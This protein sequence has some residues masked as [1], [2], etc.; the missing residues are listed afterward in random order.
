[1]TGISN[2]LAGLLTVCIH[3][4][5]PGLQLWPASAFALACGCTL[6]PCGAAADVLSISH[7]TL[8]HALLL[9]CHILTIPQSLLNYPA[10]SLKSHFAPFI[11][12][13]CIEIHNCAMSY[14]P[15]DETNEEVRLLSI[16]P[17][18]PG[19]DKLE[20]S[21]TIVSL[22]DLKPEH[23]SF[24]RRVTTAGRE[25]RLAT[26]WNSTR[27]NPALTC[28][29]PPPIPPADSYRFKWGD[30]ATLSYT[31]GDPEI[32]EAIL[33]DG[34]HASVTTNLA[35]A[36]RTFRKLNY[37]SGRFNLWVDSVCINQ[38]DLDERSSQVA[39]MRDIYA[40]SWTTMTFLGAAA[41]NSDKALGL[42]KTLA[43][44]EVNKTT[45]QLRDILQDH[46]WHLGGQ[47]E[48]LALQVFLQRR[49]WS[50]LW[51]VQ[52]SALAPP[53]MLMFAGEDSITWQEVQ[54]GL[55]SIHTCLWYVKD[56]CL[57]HD[58]RMFQ[59]AQGIS[60]QVS[61]RWDTQN[62]HH[63]DKGP[64][65]LARKERRGEPLTYKDLLEVAC[66]TACAD[67]L[68]KVYGLLAF[69][70]PTIAD[71]VV[72]DYRLQPS[73]LFFQLGQL[74]IIHDD[75]LELLRDGNPWNQTK[76]PSWAPDW[77]WEYH[78]RDKLFPTLPYQA[79]GGLPAQYSFSADGRLLTVRGV[80]VDTVEGM[81]LQSTMESENDN[82]VKRLQQINKFQTAYP[83]LDSTRVALYETLVGAR[84]GVMGDRRV[85]EDRGMQL[86]NLPASP[87]IAIHDFKQRGWTEFSIQ[88][89]RYEQWHDWR[90]RNDGM[91]LGDLGRVGDLF[92][93]RVPADASEDWLWAD[94]ARFRHM[95]SGRKFVTTKGGRFG[96]VPADIESG[97]DMGVQRGDLF[98]I[99]FGCS[100]PLVI[101]YG[102]QNYQVLGEGYLQGYMDGDILR[103]LE[104]GIASQELIFY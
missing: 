92:T 101:R 36:L 15:L 12:I 28:Q 71:Q 5:A 99:V 58:R 55:T 3:V 61:G 32:T 98:C 85:Q 46:P 33:L 56:L 77:T 57:E 50:R 52:E 102:G 49:Y 70:H 27:P 40:R 54:D 37:F 100:V 66:A 80:I 65:R 34:I 41:D 38:Q 16:S 2:L 74:F 47:G 24:P 62:L 29:P 95:A 59:E 64:T 19:E 79:D 73:Q 68:D 30:F 9:H 31:W 76:T 51:I 42:L 35:A 60:G 90:L 75:S 21:L 39:M 63:I 11:H 7:A 86:F 22:K 48:W 103:E 17:E 93:D 1:M 69:I 4:I 94:F 78:S 83:S 26:W 25:E 6:L 96:W 67:P 23:G 45:G 84:L 91:D 104:G 89:Q 13:T 88:G 8:A 72:V 97:R 20:C 44:H 87:G 10:S 43:A 14:Q 81:G 53:N 82:S 18:R